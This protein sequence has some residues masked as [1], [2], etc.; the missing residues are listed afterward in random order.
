MPG[1][2]HVGCHATRFYVFLYCVAA[3]VGNAEPSWTALCWRAVTI[4]VEKIW[5]QQYRATKG[6]KRRFGVKGVLDYLIREKLLNFAEEADRRPEFA[7]ELPSFL[8]E[9]WRIFNEYEIAGYV[10]SMKPKQRKAVRG[11]AVPAVSLQIPRFGSWLLLQNEH[12]RDSSFQVRLIQFQKLM[13]FYNKSTPTAP[14]P[15]LGTRSRHRGGSGK[16]RWRLACDRINER[17]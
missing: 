13:D 12:R 17:Q 16:G 15:L 6:I 2:G 5:V 1:A 3:A 10:A 9:V 7:R 4:R 14:I 8:A 11:A